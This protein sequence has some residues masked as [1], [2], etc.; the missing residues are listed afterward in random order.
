MRA[1]WEDPAEHA[2]AEGKHNEFMFG[3]NARLSAPVPRDG[4][5]HYSHGVRQV[6]RVGGSAAAEDAVSLHSFTTACLPLC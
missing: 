4:H 1:P 5:V 2:R 3:G 6:R